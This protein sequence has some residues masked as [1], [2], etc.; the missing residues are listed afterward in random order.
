MLLLSFCN[1]AVSLLYIKVAISFLL[2]GNGNGNKN[3]VNK[4]CLSPTLPS[5]VVLVRYMYEGSIIQQGRLCFIPI[6]ESSS[7]R[8]NVVTAQE[9]TDAL[10]K[11]GV[12]LD[13]FYPTVYENEASKGSWVPLWSNPDNPLEEEEQ[14]KNQMLEFPIK[15][16]S[17]QE[18]DELRIDVKLCRRSFS[19][20]TSSFMSNSNNISSSSGKL[21]AGSYF[22][23]GIVNPKT[24][25]NVGTLWR[26]AFQL[27]ASFLYT[28]GARYKTRSTDTVKAPSRIPLFS[29]DDINAFSSSVPRGAKWVAI[30]MDG[31]PLQSYS[32]PLNA[33]YI[34]GS[35]DAGLPKSILRSCHDVIS[36]P[37]LQYD[38][39]N[40]A[41]AGSIVMYD[42]M[43]KMQDNDKK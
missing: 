10:A 37:S 40:V 9:I 22:G 7:Y 25:T 3:N 19:T 6:K 32:H 20:A 14:E 17:Q 11:D 26:S 39:Y 16:S 1:S 29:F 13:E 35:E 36:I 5:D 42:R 2:A 8:K 43:M 38:S 24:E 27:G 34:L 23:I 4:A 15:K 12:N 41:V 30:E 21:P 28:I 18:G 33:I 31:I